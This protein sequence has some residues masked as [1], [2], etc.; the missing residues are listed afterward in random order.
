MRPGPVRRSAGRR[1][2]QEPGAEEQLADGRLRP[3]A[4]PRR[5]GQRQHAGDEPAVQRHQRGRVRRDGRVW[6]NKILRRT[7]WS[8]A[9]HTQGL[10]FQNIEM[11]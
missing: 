4:R 11:I 7:E 10:F 9:A 6:Q 8:H 1:G 5:A 3:G 2:P